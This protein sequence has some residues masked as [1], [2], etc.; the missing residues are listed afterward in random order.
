MTSGNLR[1]NIVD[2]TGESGISEKVGEILQIVGGKVV[3]V[4]KKIQAEDIDCIVSGAN[5]KIVS[6]VS[7]LFSCKEDHEKTN[8]DLRIQM[9]S[10]FAKRF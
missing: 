7:Q 4:D 3:S 8:F 9:G 1:M 2:A 6:K 5:S 10:K